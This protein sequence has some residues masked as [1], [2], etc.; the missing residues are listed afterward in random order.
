MLDGDVAGPRTLRGNRHDDLGDQ[1]TLFERGRER[2]V[3][4]VSRLELA[5]AADRAH[6]EAAAEGQHDRRHVR[7]RIG[8]RQAA[9]DRAAVSHLQVADAGRALGE[10]CDRRAL[11]GNRPRELVPGRQRSDRELVVAHVHAA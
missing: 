8:V 1:L 10:R 9:A 11:D 6:C 7:G 2:A 3:E 5:L 4:Q